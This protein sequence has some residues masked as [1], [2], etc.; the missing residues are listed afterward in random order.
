MPPV[1]GWPGARSGGTARV[2]TD[3]R[4]ARGQRGDAGGA[5]GVA[6]RRRGPEGPAHRAPRPP[7]RRD[8]APAPLAPR[9]D[10]VTWTTP[11]TLPRAREIAATVL[12][13]ELPMV[14]IEDL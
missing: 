3:R 13:P 11:T 14:T 8:A 7:A 10:L 4:T 6:R 1:P 12:D 2:R 5:R 9:S